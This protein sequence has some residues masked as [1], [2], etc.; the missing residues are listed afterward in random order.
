MTRLMK[1]SMS[2]F[3]SVSLI[4]VS[5]CAHAYKAKSPPPKATVSA[6]GI[7]RASGRNRVPPHWWESAS[8]IC[9]V[10]L[11]A[12]THFPQLSLEP[13]KASEQLEKLGQQG[14]SAVEIFAPADGGRS[15]AGLDAKN[16]YQID[17]ELGTMQDFRHLVRLAHSKGLAIITFD[18]L[19]YCSVEAPHFLKACNDVKAGRD[20]PE[21]SW[22]LWSDRADAPPPGH[23]PGDTYFMVQPAHL[24]GTTPGTFYDS[25][26]AEFWQYSERAGKYYWTKWAGV[27]SK[28]NKVRLPQYNWA[29][30]SF[31][32]EMEKVVRFWMDTGLDGMIIDAV[33]WYVDCTWEKNRR[34]MTD[35]IAS[36]GNAFS[37][38]EGGGGFHEDPTAW[39]TEGGWN[40]VQDYGLGIWWE[41]GS[42][43][44][45]K[46]IEVS[47]PRPI[48][49][50]LRDYHDRVVN[51]GG[52]LYARPTKFDQPDKQHLAVAM[53]AAAGDIIVYEGG[54]RSPEEPDA[55]AI[56]LLK[57]R[58]A[59]PA[60]Q[61]LSQRRQL[62]TNADD[63]YYAFLRIAADKSERIMVV[64]NFQSTPQTLEVDLSGVMASSLVDLNSGVE[65][66]RQ[67]RFK[68]ELP[69]Y[70]Y[71]FYQVKPAVIK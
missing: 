55:V 18:N 25:T 69:A 56:W 27:D 3:L 49:R 21:V 51:V 43:V 26:K 15:F 42:D 14:F 58:K 71:G 31:L 12:G 7:A 24:P 65:I 52:V 48:E 64:L 19:G 5:I 9:R 32:A 35:I 41:K 38:P 57:A 23:A 1:R 11:K 6:Q 22:F 20:G 67:T 50:V 37:Q 17:P 46:A 61:P 4:V 63:K 39:I 2:F 68:V 33:N 16:R 10:T 45:Q 62:P 30:P 54:Y 53:L 66:S 29:D 60:L 13:A 8:A 34:Y 47:D 59:H 28:G 70:G 44:V 36:Y 40:C